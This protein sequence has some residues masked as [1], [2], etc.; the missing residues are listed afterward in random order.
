MK[1][2]RVDLFYEVS[3]S[4]AVRHLADLLTIVHWQ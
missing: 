3:L 4:F 1:G 2:M